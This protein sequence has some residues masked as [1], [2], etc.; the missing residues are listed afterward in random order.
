MGLIFAYNMRP[1]PAENKL[2]HARK[3]NCFQP[4]IILLQPN[5]VLG[6]QILF[7]NGIR[8]QK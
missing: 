6:R 2:Q 7:L 4:N 8:W 3:N 1:F 5:F